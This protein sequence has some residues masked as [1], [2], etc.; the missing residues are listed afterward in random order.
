MTLRFNKSSVLLLSV[1]LLFLGSV[2]NFANA[3]DVI[4]VQGKITDI[5]TGE[6][7]AAVN[8]IEDGYVVSYSDIDG[9]YFCTV[10]RN[11]ELIFYSGQYEEVKVK[12]D[13]R[14]IININMT[15]KLV[16]LG[17]SIVVGK[18]SKKTIVVDQ[19]ELEV[20]GSSKQSAIVTVRE[21]A[22][23]NGWL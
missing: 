9:N 17:E 14:Q 4:R 1:I 16:E 13:N 7:I 18:M 22:S 20:V 3:Q 11:A 23:D 8:V 10:S 21:G 2:F 6:P 12:V 19:T 15:I 5:T